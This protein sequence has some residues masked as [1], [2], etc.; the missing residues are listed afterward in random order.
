MYT[1]VIEDFTHITAMFEYYGLEQSSIFPT[2][3]RGKKY[4]YMYGL[5]PPDVVSDLV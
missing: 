5:G 3:A 4:I 1:I 2:Q